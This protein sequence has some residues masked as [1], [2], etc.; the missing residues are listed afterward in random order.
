MDKIR[1]KRC[2]LHSNEGINAAKATKL[3]CSIRGLILRAFHIKWFERITDKMK[4]FMG[5]SEK[6]R[7]LVKTKSVDCHAV[8]ERNKCSAIIET[9]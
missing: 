7:P 5:E 6:V 1:I 3:I 9:L 4:H 8:W 2:T